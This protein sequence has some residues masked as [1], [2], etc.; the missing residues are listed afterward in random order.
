MI[1]VRHLPLWGEI[2]EY[3]MLA[4]TLPR[5]MSATRNRRSLRRP[6]PARMFQTASLA[7]CALAGALFAAPTNSLAATY[8][9][10]GYLD[11]PSEFPPN[12]SPGTGFA[13][14]IIDDVANTMRV[15]AD[16]SGLIGT[17]TAAHIHC[18]TT[19]PGTGTA[20]VA[21]QTPSLPRPSST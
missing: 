5:T 20:N 2:G 21:T 1:L 7:I 10:I 18:C 9:Y 8:S 19:T 12:A 4:L 16:F 11:G 13:N 3:I 14:V 17:T 6:N 15:I